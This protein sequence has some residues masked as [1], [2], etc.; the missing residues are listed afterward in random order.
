M[1]QTGWVDIRKTVERYVH[2]VDM[3]FG[4]PLPTPSIT[5]ATGTVH[6]EASIRAMPKKWCEGPSDMSSM[7][8]FIPALGWVPIGI[9]PISIADVPEY[10]AI[11]ATGTPGDYRPGNEQYQAALA[12]MDHLEE[13]VSGWLRES[14]AI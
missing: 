12:L 5:G 4:V 8:A 6:V 10:P 13:Y 1:T 7:K 14:C 11:T 2:R 9:P 3:S